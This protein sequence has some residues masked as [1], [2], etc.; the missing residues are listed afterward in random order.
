[1]EGKAPTD[2]GDASKRGLLAGRGEPFALEEERLVPK[3]GGEA[4]AE[5]EG[6][7]SSDESRS[8]A[9]G[10]RGGTPRARQPLGER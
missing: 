4:A 3:S 10:L 9:P 2:D 6:E 5:I 7:L 1:M 8:M